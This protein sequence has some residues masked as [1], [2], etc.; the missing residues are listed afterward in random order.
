MF[1]TEKTQMYDT[2]LSN[3]TSIGTLQ[4]KLSWY[5]KSV[6]DGQMDGQTDRRQR[7]DP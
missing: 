4:Q 1:N 5:N 7:S 6:T 2:R 3:L